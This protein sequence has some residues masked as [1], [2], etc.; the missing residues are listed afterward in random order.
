[1]GTVR[2]VAVTQDDGPREGTTPGKLK[3]TFQGPREHRSG[4][5]ELTERL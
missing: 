4:Q 2:E 1:M 3:P 5:R